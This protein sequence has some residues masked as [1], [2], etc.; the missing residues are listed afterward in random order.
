MYDAVDLFA[1]PGG[2]EVAGW[3]RRM[4]ILGVEIDEAACLTRYAAGHPTLQAD[5]RLLDPV[6][7][8]GVP[9]LIAS[10]PCFAAGTPVLTA[11]GMVPIEQ[12]RVGDF[13]LTHRN[14]WRKVTDT[15]QR[16]ADTVKVG[17][18]VTTPDHRF[19]TA[20]QHRQWSNERR[21]YDHVIGE[22]EWTPAAST[23]GLFLST[24][25]AIRACA[26]TT[27]P[28]GLD[29]WLV[30]RYIAD[31]WTG[32]DGV[33]IAV[34]NDKVA[35]FDAHGGTSWKTTTQSG[36]V[37][38]TW[39]NHGA[40][41]WL[42]GSFGKGAANKTLPAWVFT[43]PE[44]DRRELLDGY[45]A[46]DGHPVNNGHAAVT[47]SSCLAAGLRLL[48]VGLGMTVNV[49]CVEPPP[50]T[51]IEGRRVNQRPWWRVAMVKNDGRYTHD[52][53]HLHWSKQRKPVR[54]VG[55]S[56]VYDLTVDED[57]SFTAWGFVVHNCQ[58]FSSAGS[59]AGR[60]RFEH[61]HDH[62]MAVA[63]QGWFEIEIAKDADED[64]RTYLVLEPLRWI[65]FMQPEWIALEQVRN[66]APV[67]QS[68]AECLKV[69]GYH[70]DTGVLSAEEFGVAQTRKRAIL[71]AR[72]DCEVK[73]PAP[74][75]VPYKKGS[76][77]MVQAEALGLFPWVS[78]AEA[79]GWGMTERPGLTV[80]V[81]TDAGGADTSCVGGSGARAS[82]RRE[83][84]EGRWVQRSNY[85]AGG[86]EGM[87]AEE[88]GRT[89]RQTDEPSVTLTS[90]GFQWRREEDTV[91]WSA[92]KTFKHNRVEPTGLYG[93]EVHLP[94][95]TVT[96]ASL[97]GWRWGG[98]DP[99]NPPKDV[100]ELVAMG[101]MR[102]SNGAVRGVDEP[103]ATITSSM[104]N[105][106][107]QW[108]PGESRVLTILRA[109]FYYPYAYIVA[110]DVNNEVRR[111]HLLPD[112]SP[113]I[114][115]QSGAPYDPDW[116]DDR[117]ATTIEGRGLVANPGANANRF[118]GA[119]KSRNDGVR[120]TV[121][122]AAV[123]QSFPFDYPWQGTITAR[124]RQVGN[125]MPV[126]LALAVL[127]AVAFPDA[128]QIQEAEDQ[129]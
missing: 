24:P 123:L 101:D 66:V 6:R 69:W 27:L 83:R 75:H 96:S 77:R 98:G 79:L 100:A 95:P 124:F 102:N 28:I 70:V 22:P 46:G 37:R 78:M 76:D 40:A 67:W 125:A 35:E 53:E 1:G 110:A 30:G 3:L 126:L 41:V 9:G 25:N 2:W 29:W 26:T 71:V 11:R 31:G 51:L 21:A 48:A 42:E 73:L 105:G 61:L 120:V 18:V 47:T 16:T 114:N 129:R 36:C 8:I 122:E 23:Q 81:G 72:R 82:L 20:P 80:A 19:Y 111:K 93:R 94:A 60:K 45:L 62:I 34:G 104:D 56:V 107:F 14:R 32:R 97:A 115:D 91:L 52:K 88:R 90:K 15:M 17:P 7:Y 33:M 86:K 106:N 38:R 5:V 118:N 117:P 57:H 55:H 92:Q 39:A 87:T 63:E 99:E 12:V 116:P 128:K 119:T 65:Y 74:T 4:H 112:G 85:S 121:E 44:S 108:I 10:P 49:T 84:E 113:R 13:V 64:E 43:L 109:A 127:D 50:T 54:P 89:T 58:T 59:G 103:S 68:Y